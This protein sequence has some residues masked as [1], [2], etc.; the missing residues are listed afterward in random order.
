MRREVEL[1]CSATPTPMVFFAAYIQMFRGLRYGSYKPG[2]VLWVLRV[3]ISLLIKLWAEPAP[4][5][6]AYM[7]LDAVMGRASR[8]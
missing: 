1:S 3:V 6:F 4:P 2:E 7:F 8:A 5:A